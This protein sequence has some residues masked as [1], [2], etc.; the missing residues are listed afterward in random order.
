ML[1]WVNL[2]ALA[3]NEEHA[4]G[5]RIVTAPTKGA[6]GI[7]PAALHHYVRFVPGANDDGTARADTK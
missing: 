6:A 7:I 1:D 3:V 2:F 4:A 5:G